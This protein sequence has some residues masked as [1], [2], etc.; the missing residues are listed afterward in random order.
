MEKVV[1]VDDHPL[2][3]SGLAH[4]LRDDAQLDLV[5]D[6]GSADEAMAIIRREAIDLVLLDVLM[7]GTTG[8]S[9]AAEILAIRP[10]KLL[11]LSVLDEINTI[12]AMLRAGA[13]GYAF[14]SQEPREIAA[15]VRS[16][17]QGVPYLPPSVPRHEVF[18]QLSS[19]DETPLE[20][21]TPRER[22]VFDLMI[23][24]HTNDEIASRLFI[25]RRTVDTHR[26]HIQRKLATHSIVEMIRIAARHGGLEP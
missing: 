20:R 10:C 17:L 26:L 16:V 6:V 25:A 13:S 2:F 8:M 3:R 14:K 11:A 18:R 7:P 22:E 9:L 1:V 4:V 15:A 19:Q 12:V 21:L 5:A 24:G 23:H